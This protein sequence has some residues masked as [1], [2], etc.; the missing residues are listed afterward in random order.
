[1]KFRERTGREERRVELRITQRSGR[2]ETRSGGRDEGGRCASGG[3]RDADRVVGDQCALL[4]RTGRVEEHHDDRVRIRVSIGDEHEVGIG[5]GRA[6]LQHFV[7]FP[8]LG[9]NRR[10][11]LDRR[12]KRAEGRGD[13][14]DRGDQRAPFVRGCAAVVARLCIDVDRIEVGGDGSG[15][16]L[17]AGTGAVAAGCGKEKAGDRSRESDARRRRMRLLL[18]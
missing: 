1:M 18:R 7:P 6:E 17:D 12:R 9:L 3:R 8:L 5:T 2:V 4:G 15:P 11:D 13:L 14:D 10:R 16:A